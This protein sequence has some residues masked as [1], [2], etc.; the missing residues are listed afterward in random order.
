[1]TLDE[2]IEGTR[3]LMLS[4]GVAALPA[5][6]LADELRTWKKMPDHEKIGL[7]YMWLSHHLNEAWGIHVPA[8][9]SD[10]AITGKGKRLGH[11][12]FATRHASADRAMEF[13]AENVP[14]RGSL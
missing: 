9:F 8:L 10:A 3:E 12:A 14:Q 2:M 4:P 11:H 13:L 1:M 6:P 7:A 5:K